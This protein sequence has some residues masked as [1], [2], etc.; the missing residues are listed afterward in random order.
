MIYHWQQI[1]PHQRALF[2]EG[3]SWKGYLHPQGVVAAINKSEDVYTITGSLIEVS[4]GFDTCEDAT[5]AI[6]D[7]VR[8][9]GDTI[10]E[11]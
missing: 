6:E 7:I 11:G 5:R 4:R 8:E 1:S 2:E 3:A 9:N 10:G